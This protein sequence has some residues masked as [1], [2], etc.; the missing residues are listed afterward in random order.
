MG[1]VQKTKVNNHEK[2]Q[3]TQKMRQPSVKLYQDEAGNQ[4]MVSI[5]KVHAPP[6]QEPAKADHHHKRKSSKKKGGK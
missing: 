2:E 1:C 3:K 5:K 6:R 4:M